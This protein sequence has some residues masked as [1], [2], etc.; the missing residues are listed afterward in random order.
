MDGD[1]WLSLIGSTIINIDPID[2]LTDNQKF[3]RI[4]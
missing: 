2:Y 1:D 3:S 4:Y